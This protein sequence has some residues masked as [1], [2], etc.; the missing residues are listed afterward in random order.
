MK[1][2]KEEKLNIGRRIYEGELTRYQAAEEYDIG[3]N[4]ARSYM[5]M[6]RDSKYR[7]SG[8][9]R[10]TSTKWRSMPTPME[11]IP[12]RLPRSKRTTQIYG[13]LSLIC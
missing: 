10:T 5:R 6:Y 4:T 1:Y 3:E 11:S 2:T 12:M 9:V 8:G 7:C 13:G